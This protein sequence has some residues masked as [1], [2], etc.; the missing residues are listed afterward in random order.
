MTANASLEFYDKD[1][2]DIIYSFTVV[3]PNNNTNTLEWWTNIGKFNRF[4][5]AMEAFLDLG[6]LPQNPSY[7]RSH[8][9]GIE[10]GQIKYTLTKGPG[11]PN[12]TDIVQCHTRSEGIESGV[13]TCHQ[14]VANFDYRLDNGNV[15]TMR[16]EVTSAGNMD[17]ADGST[18]TFIGKTGYKEIRLKFDYIPPYHRCEN[19]NTCTQVIPDPPL[20]VV[21][22]ITR[23]PVTLRWTGWNDNLSGLQS[24]VLEV[25]KLSGGGEYLLEADPMTPTLKWKFDLSVHEHIVTPEE[26][27]MYSAILGVKDK[28]NNTRYT[29]EFFLY[30]STSVISLEPTKSVHVTSASPESGYHWQVPNTTGKTTI[31][32]DWTGRFVNEIHVEGGLLANVRDYPAQL[33]NKYLDTVQKAVSLE[34]KNRAANRTSHSIP[35]VNGIVRFEFQVEALSKNPEPIEMNWR[36]VSDLLETTEIQETIPKGSCK[37]VWVRAYDLVGNKEVDHGMVCFDSSPPVIREN[38]F[39]LDRNAHKEYFSRLQF[40]AV[41]RD[42]GIAMVKWTFKDNATDE[43]VEIPD[44]YKL[45]ISGNLTNSTQ[46][47][48]EQSGV[49]YCINTGECFNLRHVLKLDHCAFYYPGIENSPTHYITTVTVFNQAMQNGSAEFL[50]EDV[51]SLSGMDYCARIHRERLVASGELTS[52]GIS[53]IVICGLLVLMFVV[54]VLVLH[55]TGRLQKVKERSREGFNNIRKSIKRGHGFDALEGYKNGGFDEDDIYMYGHQTYEQAPEWK[56]R[57]DDLTI[58]NLIV[59]G[60]F[61]KIYEASLI[62][63]GKQLAVVAKTLKGEFREEDSVLMLAKINFFGTK[64]GRHSCILEMI[65]AITDDDKMGPVMI[66][67]RC[68]YGSLKEW[69]V[70]SRERPDDAAIDFLF[71]FAYSIVQGMEYLAGREIVHMRLAAR[72]VLL[73]DKLEPKISGFGPRHGD[74]E[75]DGEKK[76]RIPV[77]WIAPECMNKSKQASEKSDVWSNGVVMWEIFSFGETPYPKIRSA[78]LSRALKRGDRLSRPEYSDDTHYKIMK[79]SWNMKPERR[80]TFREIR[81][82]IEKV[83]SSTGADYYYD[84]NFAGQ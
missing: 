8:T 80:P 22:D 12:R 84:S 56:F 45:E 47:S 29:R 78:D 69:L 9:F 46:S 35:N 28:A 68:G 55:K 32:I 36:E 57:P 66:L 5:V 79:D 73:T 15:F 44:K 75:E 77:K 43:I 34:L 20:Q 49:C 21:N 83:F 3:A 33:K 51:Q 27:G 4:D 60:K 50:I 81:E 6:D 65:G 40:D 70:N 82:E 25:F 10:S 71:R 76:E 11:S 53:A 7:V 19:D 17:L 23:A 31:A 2:R 63:A 39:A 59:V 41:D 67:E 61:A 74:D 58:N 62:Q 64:V 30:D 72:N 48:C 52:G 16:Y 54:F 14:S 42:S 24:Y 26:P 1:R 38:T 37:I 18:D 13:L